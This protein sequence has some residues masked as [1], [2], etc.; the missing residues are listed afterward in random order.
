MLEVTLAVAIMASAVVA[1]SQLMVVASHQRREAGWRSLATREAA[2][3]L[4]HAVASSWDEQT[5]GALRGLRLSQYAV[6]QL[7]K[8]ELN[9]AVDEAEADSVQQKRIRI[10]VDWEN[11]AGGRSQPVELSAWMHRAK[12]V[13]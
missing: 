7:P 8:A 2:N 13:E 3:L 11:S 4:E 12:E 9:V 10:V 6:D 1:V 5:T